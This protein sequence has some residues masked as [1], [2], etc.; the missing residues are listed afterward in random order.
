[1][2]CTGGRVHRP[3]ADPLRAPLSTEFPDYRCMASLVVACET[4]VASSAGV[5]RHG[6]TIEN[7]KHPTETYLVQCLSGYDVT[8]TPREFVNCYELR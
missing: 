1:M 8:R 3:L 5:L 6:S 7:I 2:D 4:G